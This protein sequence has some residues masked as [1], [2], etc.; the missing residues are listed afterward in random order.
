MKIRK[1]EGEIQP[2][3]QWTDLKWFWNIVAFGVVHPKIN[4]KNFIQFVIIM[5][6]LLKLAIFRMI[7]QT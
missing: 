3:K 5:M 7:E 4:W 6:D 2:K 1:R